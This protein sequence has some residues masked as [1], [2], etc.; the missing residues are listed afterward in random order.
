MVFLDYEFLNLFQLEWFVLK[1]FMCLFVLIQFYYIFEL[2]FFLYFEQ[3]GNCRSWNLIVLIVLKSLELLVSIE[4][5]FVECEVVLIEEFIL[6][7]KDF[8][9]DEIFFSNLQKSLFDVNNG[10]LVVEDY[11]ENDDYG[12]FQESLEEKLVDFYFGKIDDVVKINDFLYLDENLVDL[13]FVEV[14]NVIFCF[15]IYIFCQSN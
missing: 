13:G 5:L 12:D 14:R 10:M 4:V 1:N 3:S 11:V 6:Y 8:M 2:Y 7:L 9:K 15:V